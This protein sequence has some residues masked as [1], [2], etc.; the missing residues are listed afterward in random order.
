MA[1]AD[2]KPIAA[3]NLGRTRADDLLDIKIEDSAERV[4][5]LALALLDQ[6]AEE[7]G[8]DKSSIQLDGGTL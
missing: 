5:P 6:G 8:R 1:Q 4:L 3:I 2:G 7:T